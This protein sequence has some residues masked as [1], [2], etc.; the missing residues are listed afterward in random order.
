MEESEAEE[1][2]DFIKP[3]FSSKNRLKIIMDISDGIPEREMRK[4][5]NRATFHRIIQDYTEKGLITESEGQYE[6]T[7]L[8]E[9]VI[10]S[11]EELIRIS[12]M[13]STTAPVIQKVQN[14]ENVLPD[15][16]YLAESEVVSDSRVVYQTM[17]EYVSL[18]ENAEQIK[19]VIPWMIPRTKSFTSYARLPQDLSGEV[20]LTQE[21]LD[22]IKNDF[23]IENYDEKMD[24]LNY[25]VT[26]K[27]VP[28]ILSVIDNDTVVIYVRGENGNT[29]LSS[30]S[31]NMLNWAN[32][33]Y[34]DVF[35]EAVSINLFQ[36]ISE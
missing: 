15:L 32:E 30:S 25:Y 10:P 24:D 35:D 31:E 6:L 28:F 14:W 34:E 23:S 3:L 1:A 2:I 19:E 13:Y 12:S 36:E 17:D 7:K 26:E 20:V 33:Y 8:G 16:E 21:V 9:M 29:L 5:H 18:L 27:D 11:M 22:A 4:D